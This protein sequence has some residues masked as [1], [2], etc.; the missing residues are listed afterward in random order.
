MTSGGRPYARI[1]LLASYVGVGG[2]TSYPHRGFEANTGVLGVSF[3][4]P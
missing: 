3:Y 4:F 1:G 2:N